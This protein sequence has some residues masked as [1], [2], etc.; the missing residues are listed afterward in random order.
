[1]SKLAL[2]TAEFCNDSKC[3]KNKAGEKHPPHSLEAF[4]AA[5]DEDFRRLIDAGTD[6]TGS[7][8]G[9]VI[10][11]ILA[12]PPGAIAGA[13]G[14]SAASH[15]LMKVGADISK[16]FLGDREKKRIGAVVIYSSAKIQENLNAGL[17]VRQVDFF[18]D[19]D[20]DRSA[21]EEVAEAVLLAAQREAQEKKLVYYANLLGNIPFHPEIDRSLAAL[22]IKLAQNLSYRQLCLLSLFRRG[23]QFTLRASDY[24]GNS[25]W[26]LDLISVLQETFDLY[27]QGMLN[28]SGTALLTNPDVNP[29][30]MQVQGV[31]DVLYRLMALSSIPEQELIRL[32]SIL[33]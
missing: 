13:I 21:A 10:G 16:R 14:G 6:I 22:L 15:A 8:I 24:S 23:T 30:K 26:T 12:G 28:A 2:A 1:V 5:R 27:S 25:K 29:A 11:L 19:T 18:N 7:A 33:A 31:G 4:Q 9:G 17:K 32:A 3:P 20:K